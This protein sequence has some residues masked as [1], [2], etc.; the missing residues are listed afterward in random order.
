[1]S[2]VN[3]GGKNLIILGQMWLTL[4]LQMSRYHLHIVSRNINNHAT[5]VFSSSA[6]IIPARTGP[7][8]EPKAT[9]SVCL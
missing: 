6:I 5:T 7:G 4:P 3:L 9:P 8:G 2:I 1:M